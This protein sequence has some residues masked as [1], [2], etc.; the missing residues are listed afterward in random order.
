VGRGATKRPTTAR[1]RGQLWPSWSRGDHAGRGRG[2][3]FRVGAGNFLV[4]VQAHT[5]WVAKD[6]PNDG[7]DQEGQAWTNKREGGQLLLLHIPGG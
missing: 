1:H 2:P 6:L 5:L 4:T 7:T 3:L